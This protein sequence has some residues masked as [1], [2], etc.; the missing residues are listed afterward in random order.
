MNLSIRPSKTD[1]FETVGNLM[2]EVYAQLEGFPKPNEIPEYYEFLKNVGSLTS[3]NGVEIIVADTLEKGIVGAVVYFSD[4]KHYG[5]GG[6]ITKLDNAAAFRLL[7]VDPNTRGLGIGK[8]LTKACLARALNQGFDEVYI[9][10][11]SFMKTAWSM[12]E[13][14]GFT[15]FEK[16]DFIQGDIPV[17]GFRYQLK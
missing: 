15:R 9:H 16:L 2:V 17:F 10:S 7:A 4:L 1:E 12:Y 11:T 13:R 8:Q 6:L 14:I 5:A 3:K